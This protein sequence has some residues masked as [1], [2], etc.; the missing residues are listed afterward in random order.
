MHSGNTASSGGFMYIGSASNPSSVTF[1][2]N[3]G[4]TVTIG[5]SDMDKSDKSL[6][7]IASFDESRA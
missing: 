7:S 4:A 2:A 6:D 1:T 3:G 5:S